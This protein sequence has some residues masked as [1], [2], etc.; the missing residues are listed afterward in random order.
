MSGLF[1]IIA[2]V[3]C[4]AI[5]ISSVSLF[6]LG[7]KKKVRKR[8]GAPSG[9]SGAE[10]DVQHGIPG[11]LHRIW[12]GPRV[13]PPFKDLR[14][15]ESFEKENSD[16]TPLVWKDADV[17]KLILEKYPEYEGVYS[18]YR[19]NIQRA[20]LARYLVLYEYGGM[21]ADLDMSA[22]RPVRGLVENFPKKGFFSFVEIVL[23]EKRALE[24]GEGEP[25]RKEGQRRGW[26]EIAEDQERIA[27]YAFLCAPGHPVMLE[28]LKEAGRRAGLPV[29]RQY[30]VYY[31]TG[32]D[33]FTT[34]VHR[35]MGDGFDVTMIDKNMADEF[36]LHHGSATWKT[37]INFGF[38]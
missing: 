20:D 6:R 33:L 11:L 29:K 35:C 34:V 16:F 12:I 8:Y 9:L 7:R 5:L 17:R 10:Q 27:S 24:I 15:I 28:I 3:C 26:N 36:M 38:H 14:W 1:I 21:Y 30:D 23:S 22:V 13:F 18:G 4:I 2:A 37:F 32:P 31:T 19:L 25:I